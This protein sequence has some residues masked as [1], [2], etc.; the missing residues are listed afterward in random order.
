[1]SRN[2]ERLVKRRRALE[3]L[4]PQVLSAA[5]WLHSV[6][7]KGTRPAWVRVRADLFWGGEFNGGPLRE[8][9]IC[10]VTAPRGLNLQLYLIAL[11]EAQCRKRTGVAGP[12]PLPIYSAE[13][14]EASWVRVTASQARE[15]MEARRQITEL[16]NR[17]RQVKS[18]FQRL[19]SEGLVRIIK[20][21]RGTISIMPLHE[22][23][24]TDSKVNDYVIPSGDSMRLIFLPVEFFTD[25]WIF[26]LTQSEIRMYLVLLHMARRFRK[27]HRETGVYCAGSIRDY[28]YCLS[29]DVYETHLLLEGFGLIERMSSGD[30]HFDGKLIQFHRRLERG[31][32]MPAHRFKVAARLAH[33]RNPV[34]KAKRVL[35][36]HSDNRDSNPPTAEASF[37][38][39]VKLAKRAKFDRHAF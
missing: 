9:P 39:S 32:V 25:G 24:I 6:H 19:A 31:E 20:S 16:G 1:M 3:E 35:S 7:Q 5:R 15:N 13:P 14:E 36:E 23:G 18:G 28:E 10:R 30:R 21:S 2:V 34:A 38:R 4:A 29:R 12:S 17:I 33:I 8:P 11:F 37:T 22:S 26:I 27:N